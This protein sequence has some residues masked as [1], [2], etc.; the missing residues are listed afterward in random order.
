MRIHNGGV[1]ALAAALLIPIAPAVAPAQT[2]FY[3]LDKDRPLRVED[4]YATKRYAFELKMS[5]LTLSQARDRTLQYRPSIELKHGLL[6]GLDVSA[7]VKLGVDRPALGGTTRSDTELELS[8]LLNLTTETRWLPALGL[9]VTGHLPLEGDHGSS[10]ELRG[11]ATRSLGGP[12]RA[13]L[14]AGWSPGDDGVEPWWA[15]VALDYVLP[16]RHLLLLAETYVADI[17]PGGEEE[18]GADGRSRRVHST[19]GFRYQVSPTLALDAGAGRSWTGAQG[20][21]WLLTLGLTYEFGVRGLMPGAAARGAEAAPP[22]ASPS[23]IE[24]VYH[25]MHLP[26]RHNWAFRARYPALDR[27]FA[28]FDFG[29]GIL[30]E[31]LWS[32]PDAP[33]SLLEEEIYE[34]LT[35]DILRNPPRMH[36]PEASFM[37][38]YARLVPLAKEMFEWAHVL[39]RQAYDILADERIADKDTAMAELLDYYLSSPLAFTDVPKGMEIMD[40][41]Y[42]S[43]EFRQRYP[44]FNGLIWAYHWLQVAV[45]EPLL[46]HASPEERQ[47]AMTALHARFWQMLEDPPSKLPSEMPMTAAIAPTFTERYPRFAAIF[48][49]LH[50]MHD[51]ISDILVSDRVAD[52]RAEIYRQANLFRDPSAMATT[53]EEWIAMALAHGLDAQGGPA[54]GILPTAPTEGASPGAHHHHP[55][56]EAH[57]A[58]TP[59]PEAHQ[60]DVPQPEAP[61]HHDHRH[62]AHEHDAGAGDPGRRGLMELVVRLL[63]DPEVHQRIHAV[64]ELHEGWE[65]PAVQ[66]HL[67]MMRRMHARGADMRHGEPHAAHAQGAMAGGEMGRPR[68]FIVAL[69]DDPEVHLRI[70]EDAELHRLWQD[71][72]VQAHL[73]QMR[74]MR[75]DG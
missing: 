33:T 2:D 44:R 72:D 41:Q 20:R 32:R 30:Y 3:N 48:D 61:R 53:R 37:P 24:R 70:H 69:L 13:H 59:A 75:R 16:F 55:G 63:E 34:R 54:V 14:N 50:M 52:K 58:D 38:R 67:E 43:Q 57:E 26:A 66:R 39:H 8:S 56:H 51:V 36:M 5:P 68:A 12:V 11:L 73:E 45:H 25:P 1:A 7:G 47:S 29:H 19:A 15:G 71:P 21:D 4:A 6:P 35:R 31:T 46:L 65:D 60:H 64:Q 23:P 28:A 27:L 42:F 49:N 17:A 22:V 10:V 18:V 74:Q 62:E 40:E 9:R